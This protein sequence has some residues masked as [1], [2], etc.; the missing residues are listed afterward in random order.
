MCTILK[1][2]IAT[3][4]VTLEAL[5]TTLINPGWINQNTKESH[6]KENDNK[7]NKE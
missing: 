6:D 2:L 1:T 4:L 5:I 7:E 3:F